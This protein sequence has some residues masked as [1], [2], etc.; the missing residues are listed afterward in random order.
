[1]GIFHKGG[2]HSL[3]LRQPDTFAKTKILCTLGPA[4]N[5]SRDNKKFDSIRHGWDQVK[6]FT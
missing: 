2:S 6:F 5:L 4:T 3:R 1:M